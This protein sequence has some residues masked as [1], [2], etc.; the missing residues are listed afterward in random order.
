MAMGA[1]FMAASAVAMIGW[2]DVIAWAFLD[3]ANPGAAE[4]AALA[5]TLLIVA[6][7]F[8]LSDGV[9]AV[10]AG[11]LRGLKDTAVPML[12][13]GF[14]YWVVGLPL[15]L[16][17]AFPLGYGAVGVWIGLAAGLLL[18]AGLVTRRWLRLS[19]PPRLTGEGGAASLA[20]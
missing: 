20:A 5:T 19:A 17:I 10:A 13:A 12:L 8:Q 16:L 18:V 7:L 4:T 1:A 3:P 15:G 6:G 9:Q 11:A 14:G 2:G